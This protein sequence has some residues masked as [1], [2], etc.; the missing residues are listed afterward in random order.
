MRTI[1]LPKTG[2]Y[3][4]PRYRIRCRTEECSALVELYRSELQLY[5]DMNGGLYY[6]FTCPHCQTL[7]HVLES[8]LTKFQVPDD[9]ETS[10]L[11]EQANELVKEMKRLMRW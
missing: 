2:K 8:T 9:E 1:E 10:S 4:E 11:I 3:A 6:R 7:V 5:Q